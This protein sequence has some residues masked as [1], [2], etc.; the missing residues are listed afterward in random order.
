MKKEI[1]ITDKKLRSIIKE[2]INSVLLPSQEQRSNLLTFARELSQMRNK[3]YDLACNFKGISQ[4]T[5]QEL[6]SIAKDF[7]SL[8]HKLFNSDTGLTPWDDDEY[9]YEP[10]FDED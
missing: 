5:R 1:H 4:D 2:A 9:K 7:A 8:R 3:C 10:M 6:I